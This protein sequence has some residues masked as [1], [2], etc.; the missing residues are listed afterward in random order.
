M[1]G[2]AV[3]AL[4]TGIPQFMMSMLIRTGLPSRQAAIAA[5]ET[6]NPVFVTP[7][8]IRNWLES[9]ENTAYSDARYWPA[10]DTATLWARFRTE[11][12]SGGIQKRTIKRYKRLLDTATTPPVGLYWIIT[13][14]GDGRT[15]LATE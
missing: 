9:D 1:A 15:W 12:L 11:A 5:V 3:A 13:E 8:E 2:G 10:P 7:A 4:E 14:E 6:A